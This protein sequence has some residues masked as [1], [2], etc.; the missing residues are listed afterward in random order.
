VGGHAYL[1]RGVNTKTALALCS[2]SWG[3]EWGKSGDFVLS[4]KD[5]ERL[6][7]EEGECAT[8]VEQKVRA[9]K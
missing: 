3:D 9:V 1:L 8:A 2:N 7:H 5:L 6:I 4:F